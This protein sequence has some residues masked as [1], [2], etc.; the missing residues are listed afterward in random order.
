M[1]EKIYHYI[2]K[3][4]NLI[5]N[6]IYI[7]KHST[8]N[9]EDGYLGSGTLLHQAIKKNGKENFKKEVLEIFK[10]EKDA[11]L[12]EAELVNEKFILRKDTY[13]LQ[14]G[15]IGGLSGMI[16]VKDK[17]G[18]ISKVSVNNPR[19]I[20]G[21]L[22]H[23][24]T[25]NVTAKDK[26]GNTFSVLVTDP[27]YLSGELSHI[28]LGT[29]VIKDKDG[30]KFR[31]KT[32][33]PRYLSGELVSIIKDRIV[34][35]DQEGNKSSVMINDPRYLSGELVHHTKNETT[36]WNGEDKI[37]V[38]SKTKNKYTNYHGN[39]Y[40]STTV[41]DKDGNTFQVSIYDPR[42][43]SGELLGIMKGKVSVKDQLGNTMSVSVNDPRY[44][45]GELV[46]TLTKTVTVRDNDGN[47]FRVSNDNP[48]YLSGKYVGITKGEVDAFDMNQ[49]GKKIRVQTGDNRFGKTIFGNRNSKI[50]VLI[51]ES[52]EKY[53]IWA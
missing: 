1:S 12:K 44:I 11:F 5:N 17:N 31:V 14:L 6:K 32:S 26:N 33:D 36:L 15:G 53:A 10:T 47:K 23:H 9:L 51:N 16:I 48:E 21:E 40:E 4:T 45:S 8:N 46:Y 19:Y 18:K 29:V 43:L 30:N 28:A 13:N 41:R 20:S 22:I 38:L 2:Y 39:Q 35:K 25:G 7:G 37:R 50:K 24:T 27:R 3:T 34:V 49:N 52:K 42:Y